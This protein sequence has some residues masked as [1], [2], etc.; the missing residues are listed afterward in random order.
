MYNWT[1][2]RA[3]NLDNRYDDHQ[4]MFY[5]DKTDEYIA[6]TRGPDFPPRTVAIAHTQPNTQFSSKFTD[7]VVV[8]SGGDYNQTYSQ[9]TFK[10]YNI[11]LGLVMI[12]YSNDTNGRVFC[13]LSFST[14]LN[15][16]YRVN[17][18]QQLIPLSSLNSGQFDSHVCFAAAYP[19]K[20][21]DKVLLY[22]M[23]GDGPHSGT[24]NSS[25]GLATMRLDGFAGIKNSV[26]GS[27]AMMETYSI[28]I[29]GKYMIITA[30]VVGYV[31]VALEGINGFGLN[32]C[33][34]IT[35]DVTDIQVEWNGKKDISSL[36]GQSVKIQFELL[37]S[38]LY[39][40]GFVNDSMIT[41]H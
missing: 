18:G 5:D 8:E 30:D 41:T 13:E 14:N 7:A 24:R 39:T 10:Y 20:L 1:N 40:F 3:L 36:I 32:D 37:D 9:I 31:K 12:F 28:Q 23:G 21:D 26:K 38:V 16:W 2:F 35:K 17:N 15:E 29:T 22:Y 11:Y 25:F 19:I 27:A 34:T 33:D 4:N 6:V